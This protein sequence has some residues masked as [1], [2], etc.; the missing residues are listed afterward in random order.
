MAHF[1]HTLYQAE[2]EDAVPVDPFDERAAAG[3]V[4]GG[5]HLQRKERSQRM[6]CGVLL[7]LLFFFFGA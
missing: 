7:S 3:G 4:E 2:D 5:T 6:R 1:A